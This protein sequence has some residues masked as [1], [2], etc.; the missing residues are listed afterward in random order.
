MKTSNI[1]KL[2]L[3]LIAALYLIV[4]WSVEESYVD[5][6]AG[7]IWEYKTEDDNPFT[8][9]A[10]IFHKEV[11]DVKDGYVLYI[12]HYKSRH[13]TESVKINTFL[14]NT[15]LTDSVIVKPKEVFITK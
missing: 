6:S 2:I 7:Q 15:T 1:L 5:I 11:L 3:L 4:R 8:D 13:N 10:F 9:D 12:K 14:R